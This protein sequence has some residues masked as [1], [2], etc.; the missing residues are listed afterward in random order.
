MGMVKEAALQREGM[1]GDVE[2]IAVAVG[3][4]E[5]CE[6]HDDVFISEFPYEDKLVEAYKLAN[7]R[8]TSGEI[9][10]PSM[11]TRRDFTDLIKE[12][13]E[14]APDECPECHRLFNQK[15]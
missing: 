14:Q 9:D 15:D 5:F 13:V 7:A 2:A 11:M 8:I 10:L 6:F 4:G 3:L 12:V 1:I